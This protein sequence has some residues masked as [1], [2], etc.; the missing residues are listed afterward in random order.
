MQ[1][2]G[3]D[4]VTVDSIQVLGPNRVVFVISI[5]R[6]RHLTDPAVVQHAMEQY[7]AHYD[8]VQTWTAEAKDGWLYIHVIGVLN[9][10]DLFA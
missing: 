1:K 5:E 10:V 6:H 4:H 3:L 7:A 9:H 8:K 2:T